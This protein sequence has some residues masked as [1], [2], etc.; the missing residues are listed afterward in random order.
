LFPLSVEEHKKAIFL[1]KDVRIFR[2]IEVII[3]GVR[4]GDP[5]LDN[6]QH[7]DENEDNSRYGGSDADQLRVP[8]LLFPHGPQPCETQQIP[9][10]F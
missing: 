3:V 2:H 8:R 9:R 1:Q 4:V 6:D 10:C 7:H 5:P